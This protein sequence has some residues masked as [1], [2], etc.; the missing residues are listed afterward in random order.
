MRF[1]DLHCDTLGRTWDAYNIGD[2]DEN[3]V[4]NSYDVSLEKA[5]NYKPYIGC[6]AIWIPD[7]IRGDATLNLFKKAYEKLKSQGKKHPKYFKIIKNKNDL[8][9][10]K[11]GIIFTVEGGAALAG[12]L[13]NVKYFHDCGVKIMTLTWNGSCELG[14][15]VGVENA[16]GLTPFGV[17]V[18]KKMEKWGIVVD[19]SHASEALFYDVVEHATK[20]F[21]ATHSNSKVQCPH[22]RNLTDEQ[23]KV[24]KSVGGVVGLTFAK[25]F[26]KDK[27]DA[28]F[29]DIQRHA[30]HF[31]AL[32]GENTV[33][34]GT[35]FD[36]TDMPEGM[37]GIESVENLYE[38]FLMK[39]YK[40]ELVDKMF[41]KNAHD[42]M[43][44]FL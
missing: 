20:P 14:D 17:K 27:N 29:E 42:F 24:I 36:G 11:N 23:F 28:T 7:E 12:D 43:I 32:G 25:L 35:D 26:L 38:Y 4:E 19:V 16:K 39:N 22:Q 41:F 5:E 9:S 15:G 44:K 33:C 3:F 31:L 34:I 6:F 2:K 18:V 37:H 21:L 1:F 13:N 8:E 40:E 30:E 10:A